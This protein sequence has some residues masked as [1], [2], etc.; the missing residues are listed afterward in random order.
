MPSRRHL[1]GLT[2]ELAVWLCLSHLC[3]ALAS[4]VGPSEAVESNR[5]RERV[6]KRGA[7][8]PK[9]RLVQ[10]PYMCRGIPL[11]RPTGEYLGVHSHDL[12]FAGIRPK[13]GILHAN[14]RYHLPFRSCVC[15][16]SHAKRTASAKL[17]IRP[18]PV[19]VLR[20]RVVVL[21][22]T[23]LSSWLLW[24]RSMACHCLGM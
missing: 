15:A 16:P 13:S 17:S 4:A 1:A 3:T 12:H 24:D 2:A 9:H 11:K 21:P 10:A 6:G 23:I 18:G 8:A 19:C 22:L 5:E 7:I 14:V 20:F